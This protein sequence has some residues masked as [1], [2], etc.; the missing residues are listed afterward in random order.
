MRFHICKTFQWIFA[1]LI[2]GIF[3]G[4]SSALFIFVLNLATNFRVHNSSIIWFLPI[5]G[6]LVGWIYQRFGKLASKG[7]NLI[8]EEIQNTTNPIPLRIAPLI[9]VGTT[10]THLFGGSA[11]REGS[12]VQMTT[13]LA[14][15]ASKFFK[16]NPEERKILLMSAAGAGFGSAV[17]AP[18]AGMIFG[19]E[20]AYIGK[21]HLN[22]WPQCLIASFTGY[23]VGLLLKTPHLHYPV[24]IIPDWTFKIFLY[25]IMAGVLFGLAAL[26]FSRFTYL[27]DSLFKKTI[28]IPY[29][30][31][32]I[33]GLILVTLFYVEGSYR[34]AGLGLEFI[35]DSFGSIVTFRDPLLK[36][37]FTSLTVGSGFKGGEFVPL[38]FI[39]ATLGSALGIIIPIS[40]SFLAALGFSAVFAGAANTPLAC[41]FMAAE[42]FGWK[43]FFYAL[44]TCYTSYYFSG[45]AGIY[46][47]QTIVNRKHYRLKKILLYFSKK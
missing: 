24:L 40:F 19:M 36:T 21:L 22:S 11:G 42:I 39:G 5:A 8:I 47:S 17:G 41:A 6:L 26:I 2:V 25:V 43:I 38:V 18:I 44:I 29:L 7:N 32:M 30:I 10:L 31:P 45:H 14:D 1:C 46:R 16:I 13:A 33:G 9:I 27:I 15:Q 4:L 20:V 35:N 23:Y 37:F 34:Y 3:A 28:K 12:I